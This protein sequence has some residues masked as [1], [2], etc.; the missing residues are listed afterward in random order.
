MPDL[1]CIL[2]HFPCMSCKLPSL[3][4]GY[5]LPVLIEWVGVAVLYLA[6]AN[7]RD[8]VFAHDLICDW[9]RLAIQYL[10]LQKDHWIWIPDCCFQKASRVL[11]V[12]RRQHLAP[13]QRIHILQNLMWGCMMFS[14]EIIWNS[15]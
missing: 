4:L 12:V 5:D 7:G 14:C 3:L 1:V 10:I 9:E 11:S 13:A 8:K 6:L 15:E 2:Q